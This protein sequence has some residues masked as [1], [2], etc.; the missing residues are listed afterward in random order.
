MS[1][2]RPM[3]NNIAHKIPVELG[4]V[5]C[6]NYRTVH[7]GV[8]QESSFNF[9]QFNA[10]ALD[11]DLKIFSPKKFDIAIREIATKIAGAIEAF[12]CAWMVDKAGGCPGLISPVPFCY[13]ATADIELAGNPIRAS[14]RDSLST[15]NC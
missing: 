6:Y 7:L 2:N 9:S 3:G 15:W 5:R 1:C 10:V 13:S 8:P 12:S 14:S 4:F 11:L